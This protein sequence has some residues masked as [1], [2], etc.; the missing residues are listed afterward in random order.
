MRRQL[1]EMLVKDIIT[2]CGLPLMA[3]VMLVPKK[4][5]EEIQNN[6][7]CIEFSRFEFGSEDT[8]GSHT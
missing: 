7:F 8:S 6:R 3:P 2:P 5:P 1:D 4:S